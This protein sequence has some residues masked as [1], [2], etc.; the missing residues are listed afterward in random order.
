MKALITGITG[1]VGSYLAE[2]LVV[3]G[4]Y[5]VSG[6]HMSDDFI[7]VSSIKDKLD[8]HKID[9]QNKEAVNDLI[10]K[11]NPDV[12]FHLAAFTSPAKSFD[13]PSGVITNNVTIQIN[14]LEAVKKT[15]IS[16]KILI[17]SSAEIYGMVAPSDIPI[18]ERVPFNPVNPYAVSKVAQDRLGYQYSVSDKLNIIIARPQN[19]IGPRQAP[20]FVVADFA[21]QIADI[22]KGRAEPVIKVGNLSAKR[23]FT[24]VRDIVRAYVDLIEKG[25]KGEAYNLGSGK[26]IK[27]EDILNKL[28]S[29]SEKEIKVEVDPAK[30]RP[31]DVPEIFCDNSK[32]AQATGWQP[33][34]DIDTTLEETLEYWRNQE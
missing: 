33:E 14:L 28:L 7:N 26:S 29:F 6:T 20:G 3:S 12:I 31:V 27:I 9:L 8:L 21:K 5:E 19:N 22:E 2:N 32:I 4:R 16:P 15:Q 10:E 23:D 18:N 24:D 34:I 13:D 1:F 25:E 11:V 30:I 17:V